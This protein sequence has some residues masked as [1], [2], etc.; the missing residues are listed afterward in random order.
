MLRAKKLLAITA[1]KT[2]NAIITTPRTSCS[3][4]VVIAMGVAE[5]VGD[6]VGTG[7]KVFRGVG[8]ILDPL[9]VL[10]VSVVSSTGAVSVGDGVGVIGTPVL[11]IILSPG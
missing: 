11:M 7:V 9:A 8:V 6:A 3:L 1:R 5:A 2:K 10:G 4:P